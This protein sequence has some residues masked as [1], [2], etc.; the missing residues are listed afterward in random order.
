MME[1]GV[2]VKVA[3]PLVVADKMRD[4]RMFDV[5]RVSKQ[6]LIG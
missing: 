2:I 1:H 4:A 6:G 5:V 3:G